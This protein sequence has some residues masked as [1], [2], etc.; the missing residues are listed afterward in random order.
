[1]VAEPSSKQDSV[2]LKTQRNL[3]ILFGLMALGGKSD[4]EIAK[5]LGINNTTLSRGRKKLEKEGYIKEYTI[6][7]DF[8]KMGLEFLVFTYSSTTDL[9]TP[10]QSKKFYEQMNKYPN[11]LCV[12]EDQRPTGTNWVMVSIHKNYETFSELCIESEKDFLSLQ[13]MPHAETRSFMFRT[14]NLFPKPFSLQNLEQLFQPVKPSSLD[15][16]KRYNKAPITS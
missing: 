8:H 12:L 7:P 15:R 6:I 4:R 1:M 16:N 14:S 3:K 9:V 10:G 13:P 11:V 5:N 2:D